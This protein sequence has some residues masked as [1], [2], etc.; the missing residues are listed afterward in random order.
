VVRAPLA[1]K[2]TGMGSSIGAE[3][4]PALHFGRWHCAVTT[5]LFTDP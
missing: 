5:R 1:S 2:L 4:P 3:T